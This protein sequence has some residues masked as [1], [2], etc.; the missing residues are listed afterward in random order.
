MLLQE[1][2]HV[3]KRMFVPEQRPAKPSVYRAVL[4]ENQHTPVLDSVQE[5]AFCGVSV[6][7]PQKVEIAQTC[8][9]DEVRH[10]F[11]LSLQ[12]LNHTSK[13]RRYRQRLFTETVCLR[14]NDIADNG[15]LKN[16][17]A[18]ALE[19]RP[20]ASYKSP[21]RGRPCLMRA[22]VMIDQVDLEAPRH[23]IVPFRSGMD[24]DLGFRR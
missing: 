19:R 10:T 17:W 3:E 16:H 9:T 18:R 4:V 8:E 22:T 1:V 21:G 11:S 20:V 13:V 14:L 12:D 23:G 7:L 15:Y 6:M 2:D 5:R 24:R